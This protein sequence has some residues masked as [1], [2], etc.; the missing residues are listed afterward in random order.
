M[1]SGMGREVCFRRCLAEI[2]GHRFI[3]MSPVVNMG[4]LFNKLRLHK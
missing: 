1:R 4:E 2:A 3:P